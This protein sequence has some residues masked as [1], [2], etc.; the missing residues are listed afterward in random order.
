M[1]EYFTM[2]SSTTIALPFQGNR[3]VVRAKSGTMQRSTD[4]RYLFLTLQDG[5]F[6]D[7]HSPGRETRMRNIAMMRGTFEEDEIRLDLTGLGLDRTDDG[8]LQGPLQD[9]H[10]GSTWHVAQD[11]LE[12]RCTRAPKNS[13]EHL[14]NSLYIT[15]KDEMRSDT[16]RAANVPSCAKFP[17]EPSN[18]PDQQRAQST[19]ML[20]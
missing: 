2:C 4:G 14:A 16:G 19:M 20:P 18:R 12:G 15:R 6:Y 7:E 9:A 8:S 10:L 1:A 5:H 17:K 3:T 11:S 13:D